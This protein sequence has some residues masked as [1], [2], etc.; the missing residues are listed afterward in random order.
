MNLLVPTKP[1]SP[2][3]AASRTGWGLGGAFFL[4]FGVFEMVEHGGTTWATGL[5][6]A[7]APDIPLLFGFWGKGLA[8]SQLSPKVVPFYNAT[9]HWL[10]PVLVIAWF[11]LM[12]GTNDEAAPGFTLGVMWLAHIMVDRAFGYGPRNRAGFQRWQGDPA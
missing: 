3:T 4:A 9:H 2:P 10:P 5:I 6:G 7:L 11:S 8:K 1:T 12:T